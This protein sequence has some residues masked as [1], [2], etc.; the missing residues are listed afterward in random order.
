MLEGL[1]AKIQRVLSPLLQSNGTYKKLEAK[2]IY[3]LLNNKLY[4]NIVTTSHRISQLRGR[5]V[6]APYHSQLKTLDGE[7]GVGAVLV[8]VIWS[9]VDVFVVGYL[10]RLLW[11]QGSHLREKNAF[12]TQKRAGCA[13]LKMPCVYS[14][15]KTVT[16]HIKMRLVFS[17]FCTQQR[18]FVEHLPWV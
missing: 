18:R 15:P 3:N 4:I 17:F 2:D 9:I 7:R 6:Q 11:H 13:N 1:A 10:V 14:T 12:F 5:L 16:S 8:R